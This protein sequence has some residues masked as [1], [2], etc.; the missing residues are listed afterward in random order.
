MVKLETEPKGI[1]KMRHKWKKIYASGRCSSF[2]L[3]S[4]CEICGCKKE[5]L[6][7]TVY[8]TADGGRYA[9]SPICNYTK[10]ESNT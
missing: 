10:N 6:R 8:I 9:K 4:I 3:Y 1:D 7:N 2:V 5:T